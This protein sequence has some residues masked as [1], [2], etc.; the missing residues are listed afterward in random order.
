MVIILNMGRALELNIKSI[1]ST[2]DP[3]PTRLVVHGPGLIAHCNAL[4]QVNDREATVQH[5]S[6]LRRMR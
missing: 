1:S 6:N 2:L 5:T 3:K 4:P